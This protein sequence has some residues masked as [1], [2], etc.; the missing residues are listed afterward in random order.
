[1]LSSCIREADYICEKIIAMKKS[2]LNVI[3][4]SLIVLLAITTASSVILECAGGK[5]LPALRSGGLVLLHIAVTL[6]LMILSYLH[7]KA[8]FGRAGQWRERF[9]KTKKQNRWLLWI[10]A[11]TLLTGIAAIF[12]YFVYG[13]TPF[14]AIHGKIGFVA[15]LI[16]LLHLLH[17]RRWLKN[18]F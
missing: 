17:R 6:A 4:L 5:D 16:M 12:T 9:R 14:G 15:L 10:T 8:H 11:I 3:N 18:L 7:I 1:M 13:H 2:Q